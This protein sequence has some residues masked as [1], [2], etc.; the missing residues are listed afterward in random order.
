MLR[1]SEGAGDE[2]VL[3]EVALGVHGQQVDVGVGGPLGDLGPGDVE[4]RGGPPH[5]LPVVE[6]ERVEVPQLHQPH[7][8]RGAQHRPAIKRINP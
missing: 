8:A 5:P 1:A 3:E 7:P 2:A 6:R 4:Q